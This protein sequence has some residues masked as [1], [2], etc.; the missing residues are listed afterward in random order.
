MSEKHE[1]KLLKS[2][3]RSPRVSLSEAVTA[4]DDESL[5]GR[6][7]QCVSVGVDGSDVKVRRAGTVAR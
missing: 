6:A 3:L 5:H 2:K 7:R 4:A 1:S